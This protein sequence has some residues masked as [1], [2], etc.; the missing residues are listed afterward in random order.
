MVPDGWPPGTRAIVRRERAHP[1]AQM[2]LWDLDGFRFQVVLTDQSGDP[3]T[4]EAAHRGHAH[5]EDH[6]KTLK[7]VGLAR[8]PF[9]K[10]G[11]NRIWTLCC[12]LAQNLLRWF[13]LLALDR[14]DP[15]AAAAPKTLRY[16]L[17]HVAGHIVHHARTITVRIERTWPW[18]DT[19]T[20]AWTRICALA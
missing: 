2:R 20:T 10:A 4:V 17:L 16:R 11:A 19:F 9:T 12:L 15:L 18:A 5:V 8:M 3:V 6:V 7:D 1:G 13:Q 14:D